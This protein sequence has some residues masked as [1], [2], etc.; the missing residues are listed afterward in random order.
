M[1]LLKNRY[2]FGLV[3]M[4]AALLTATTAYAFDPQLTFSWTVEDQVLSF[5]VENLENG[6][7]VLFVPGVCAPD[8]LT[9][10]LGKDEELIWN[11]KVIRSGDEL[12][13]SMDIGKTV[14]VSR[15]SGGV[16]ADVQ[17]MR[18]SKIP[19]LFITITPEDHRRIH[20]N[21]HH[22]IKNDGS[23]VM[24]DQLGAVACADTMTS[25]HMRGNSTRYGLKKPY[26]LKLENKADLLGM[27]KSRTWILLANWFDVSLLR[28]QITFDLCKEIGLKG[29][30]EC[31]QVDVYLNNSYNGTYLLTEKIQLNKNRLDITN[32]EKELEK[33]NDRPLDTYKFKASNQYKPSILR[34]RDIPNEPE[35]ITGGFL[36]EIEKALQF[37]QNKEGSGF[38]TEGGMCVIIKEPTYTGLKAANYIAEIVNDFH[39]GVLAPDGISPDTGRHYSEYIDM[40]S[41][42]LKIMVEEL[43]ANFDVRAASQFMYKDSSTVDDKLYA[44]PGWDYDL[45]YGNK[46]EGFHNPD[47][48]DYVYIRSSATSY[49]YHWM[50]THDDFRS[51]SRMLFDTVFMPAVEILLG[52]R[53]PQADSFLRSIDDYRREISASAA[54][55]FTRWNPR[56][57]P[58]QYE[59][60][61]RTFKDANVFLKDWITRRIVAMN[62]QWLK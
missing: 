1:N 33:L 21:K 62:E 24:I 55:N 41:F 51:C 27:G 17:V 14:S 60:S 23:M 54:M 28:N 4:V 47:R 44:G 52:Q 15:A 37:T 7:H 30:P 12:D 29:T 38:K 35:D 48:P 57:I 59:P 61:G 13:I 25:F 8:C 46:D 49:L 58:E 53:D 9:V 50:L 20:S 19:S 31:H 45:T 26:Q 32:M 5:S 2:L 39:N 22:D 40:N 43:S 11:G 16:S 34:W 10:A 42:A 56:L 18:G 3:L 6:S 36:L